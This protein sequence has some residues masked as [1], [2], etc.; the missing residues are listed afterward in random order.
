MTYDPENHHRRSIRLK[1]Y[2]YSLA[3]AYFITLNI[4]NC[5]DLLGSIHNGKVKL[6]DA[7]RI[8]QDI[9]L[10]LEE[11]PGITLDEWVVMPDHLH[12]ILVIKD[13]PSLPK[14]I[15]SGVTRYERRTMTLPKAIGR[16]KMI[17]AKLINQQRRTP[18]VAVW[19][20][21][22]YERIIRDDQALKN[23]RNYIRDN[24]RIPRKGGS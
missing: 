18:G 13:D 4:D 14:R 8:V 22:Y 11:L 1:G 2:D 10:Q 12:G 17:S 7:G 9:W 5:D 23:I 24:P 19:Q 6:S 21:D 20:R 3:G 15:T 16:F